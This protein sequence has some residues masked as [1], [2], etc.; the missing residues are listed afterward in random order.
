[1]ESTN[2]VTAPT[3][4]RDLYIDGARTAAVDGHSYSVVDPAT[5]KVLCDVSSGGAAD[6]AAAVD[7]AAAAF[8]AGARWRPGSARRSCAVPT[9]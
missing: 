1:M 7:A 4:V 2:V 8:P 6:A 3:G 5:A 9:T